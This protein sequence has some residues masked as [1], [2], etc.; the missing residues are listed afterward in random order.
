LLEEV[1]KDQVFNVEVQD[2]SELAIEFAYV[3]ES[4]A[5]ESEYTRIQMQF[6]NLLPVTRIDIRRTE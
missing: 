2:V 6:P 5:D 1:T 3:V 4:D